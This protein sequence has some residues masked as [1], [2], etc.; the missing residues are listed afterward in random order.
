MWCGVLLGGYQEWSAQDREAEQGEL[1]E[2]T[3]G[4][5]RRQTVP[6]ATTCP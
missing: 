5:K 1:E 2:V 6:P 3:K 4:T